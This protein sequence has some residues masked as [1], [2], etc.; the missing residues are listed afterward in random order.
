MCSRALPQF[1][2]MEICLIV[3][4]TVVLLEALV[5]AVFGPELTV[6]S[7]FFCPQFDEILT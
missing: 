4:E 7:A 3:M 6:S 5:S 1:I 2:H